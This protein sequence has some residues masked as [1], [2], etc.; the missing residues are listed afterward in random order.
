MGIA[1]KKRQDRS[2]AVFVA[3]FQMI[4]AD[5]VSWHHLFCLHERGIVCLKNENQIYW[6]PLD[7]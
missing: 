4:S 6:G 5:K 2:V 7:L 1:E 3:R